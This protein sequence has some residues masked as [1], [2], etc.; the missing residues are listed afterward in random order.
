MTWWE[1]NFSMKRG[2]KG[3]EN[4]HFAHLLHLQSSAS[5]SS[6][7]PLANVIFFSFI[8]WVLTK[9]RPTAMFFPLG[10]TGKPHLSLP[11]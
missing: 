5:S 10:E 8:V 4:G 6:L 1:R 7:L 3:P 9:C 11:C 2:T